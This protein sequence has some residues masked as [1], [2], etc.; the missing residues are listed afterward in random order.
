V[1]SGN[2]HLKFDVTTVPFPKSDRQ[3][4]QEEAASGIFVCFVVGIAFSLIP[5]SIVSRIVG[6]KENGLYHIQIVSGVEKAAYYGSF[7]LIDLVLS[8]VPVILTI[9]LFNHFNLDYWEAWKT[10]M[11]YPLAVIPFTYSTSFLFNKES[12][13]QTFTIYLHFLLSAIASMVVFALRMV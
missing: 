8:Y 11:L 4:S 6:E 9:Y 10:L 13:A 5:A 7:V 3:R 2:P 12:T 1:A